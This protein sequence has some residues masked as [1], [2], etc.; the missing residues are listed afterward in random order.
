MHASFVSQPM[1][2]I[3]L[4]FLSTLTLA[5]AAEPT[6]PPVTLTFWVSGVECV[7][8]VDV[9]VRSVTELKA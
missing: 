8:C 6:S 2:S 3:A 1:K 5:T 4:A 7:S 9:I